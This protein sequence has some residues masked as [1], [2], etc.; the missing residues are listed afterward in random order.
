LQASYCQLT[1]RAYRSEHNVYFFAE[2]HFY[3]PKRPVFGITRSISDNCV[4]DARS[5]GTSTQ[6]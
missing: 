4:D 1:C 3:G 6:Y 5:H 2:Q